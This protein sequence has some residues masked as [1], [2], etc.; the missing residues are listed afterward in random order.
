MNNEHSLNKEGLIDGAKQACQDGLSFDEYCNLI[1]TVIISGQS[2]E[3]VAGMLMAHGINLYFEGF[4]D[5]TQQNQADQKCI[6]KALTDRGG[7]CTKTQLLNQTL[8]I[9]DT[10]MPP[11]NFFS[12]LDALEKQGKINQREEHGTVYITFNEG[13]S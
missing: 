8:H 9:M 6:L 4:A 2:K 5:A 3:E 12:A 10:D 13:V 11:Y 1:S 7:E